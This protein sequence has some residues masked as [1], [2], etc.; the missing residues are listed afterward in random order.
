MCE[1]SRVLGG[2]GSSGSAVIQIGKAIGATVIAVA[3]TEEKA[4][5]CKTLGADHTVNYREGSIHEQVLKI[6]GKKGADV[7]FDPVGGSAGTDALKAI[8]HDGRFV[9]IGF[10]AGSWTKFEPGDVVGRSYS[11]VG[12]FMGNRRRAQIEEAKA[13]LADW[14]KRGLISPPIDQVFAFDEVP[15]LMTRLEKGE[16]L[17]KMVLKVADKS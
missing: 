4:A 14:V 11:V 9:L 13:D 5:F 6:T 1:S 3:G 7:I 8:A 16:M 12:A 17:G 10:A 2:S 15:Q